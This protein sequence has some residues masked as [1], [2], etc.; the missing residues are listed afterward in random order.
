MRLIEQLTECARLWR[1]VQSEGHAPKKKSLRDSETLRRPHG[2][3]PPVLLTEPV[4][5]LNQR[6]GGSD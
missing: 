1:V 5:Y 3:L 2:P 4:C 6:L